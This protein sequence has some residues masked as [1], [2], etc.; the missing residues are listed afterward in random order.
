M[1]GKKI[2]ALAASVSAQLTDI[3]PVVQSGATLKE[4]LSQVVTLFNSTLQLASVSQVTGLTSLLNTFLP[5]AGGTMSGPLILNSGPTVPL[6]A[7]TKGYVDTVATGFTVILA[8]AAATTAN[9]NATQAGAGIGATL[10]NAGAM[11]AFSVDG[12]SANVNDR[13]LVKNQTATQ[14]NGIYAVTTVGSGAVNWVLT[15]T[16]DYDTAAQ[17]HPGTLVAVN[18]GTANANT[19]WL[20]TA[21]VVTV[22]TDPVLFSQFTFAPSSFLQVMNNLSDVASASSSR[23]NLGL[24]TAATKTAS[25]NSKTNV[26]MVNGA[27][28]IGHLAVFSD[29]NGTVQDGGPPAT[30]I[31]NAAANGRITLTSGLP[32][33]PSNVTAATTV[34][35][36]PY[37]GNQI[38]LFDGAS[39][40]NTLPFSELSIAVPATTNTMYDLFIYNNLGTPTLETQGWTNDTTRAVGLVLQNGVYVK[41]G[42]TTRRYLGSF[43]TTGVSGQTEDSLAKRYVWNYYNRIMRSMEVVDA[44]SSWNYSTA[45]WRQADGSTANQLDCIIGVSEDNISVQA[46]GIVVNSTATARQAGTGIGINSTSANSAQIMSQL[47][48]TTAAIQHCAYYNNTLSIGRNFI[49]WL[50]MGAGTDTQTW[51]GNNG[52]TVRQTGII[53]S[54]WG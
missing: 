20:E 33:T 28:T 8:C 22:D 39:T 14:H 31:F 16:T 26:A 49:V 51:Y 29:V 30:A 9:L 19:S 2:S 10:T 35:F 4:S 1:A 40:W 18:N 43:R 6:Q 50:E 45:T 36:T 54:T 37:K 42:A 5:L 23:T 52:S 24:G 17:I 11:A 44:S 47:G 13:I 27:T 3:F 46:I 7:A 34:Y 38:A 21:T 53:G 25:D 41:N 15:R 48:T 32:V 12:Y